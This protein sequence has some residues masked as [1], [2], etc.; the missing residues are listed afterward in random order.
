VLSACPHDD[1]GVSVQLPRE[2]GLG[3]VLCLFGVQPLGAVPV[4]K[5][6]RFRLFDLLLSGSLLMMLYE[7][8]PFMLIVFFLA[9]ILLVVAIISTKQMSS[10]HHNS[11]ED[12]SVFG[13][14][15]DAGVV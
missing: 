12:T 8:I 9:L 13:N 6:L 2:D 4:D 10:G 14:A 15:T 1:L 3:E 7:R 11:F 5:K